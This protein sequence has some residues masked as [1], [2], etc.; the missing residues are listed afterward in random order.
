MPEEKERSYVKL[1]TSYSAYFKMLSAAEVGRLTMAMIDYK[2]SGEEPELSGNERFVWPAIQRDID[3][4]Q[5]SAEAYKKKQAENGAKGGRPRKPTAFSENPKNPSLFSETQKSQGKRTKDYGQR[6][7]DNTEAN[8]STSEPSDESLR[9]NIQRV[10]EAWNGIA[11]I[12]KIER[13]NSGSKRYQCLKARLDEYGVDKV[14]AAIEK[15]KT[16]DFLR[17]KGNKGWWI[18]FDWFVLPNNLPK[19]LEGNYDNRKEGDEKRSSTM[20]LEAYKEYDFFDE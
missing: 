5:R 20:D 16:S 14:L 4:A 2:S 1:W 10:V 6:T 8:A 15:V 9:Q 3:E 11:G 18:T 7:K 13:I 17:G 12:A 19:V